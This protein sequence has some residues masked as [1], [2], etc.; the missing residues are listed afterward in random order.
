MD[1]WQKQYELAVSKLIAENTLYWSR[2]NISLIINS[3][4][5]VAFSTLLG[6]LKD[7]GLFG[8]F[9]IFVIFALGIFFSILWLKITK[10]GREWTHHYGGVIKKIEEDHIEE[11]YRIM[12]GKIFDEENKEW[13]NK[14]SESITKKS[15][16]YPKG[17]T[18]FWIGLTIIFT[19]YSV[20]YYGQIIQ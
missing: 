20:L 8:T 14:I 15:L 5:V 18:G 13:K 6:L 16:W 4:L 3:G 10:I 7:S 12:A 9:S 1:E 19:I 2:F 11:K 17:F